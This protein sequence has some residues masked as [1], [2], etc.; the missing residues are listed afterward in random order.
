MFLQ[1]VPADSQNVKGF[2]NFISVLQPN[3][4][5]S[6]SWWSPVWLNKKLGG[7]K[8]KKEPLQLTTPCICFKTITQLQSSNKGKP[9]IHTTV[10]KNKANELQK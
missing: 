9:Q 5:K 8:R 1:Q 7:K 6:S 2:L 3:L 4:A 10:S